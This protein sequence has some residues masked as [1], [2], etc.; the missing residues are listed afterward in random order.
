VPTHGLVLVALEEAFSRLRFSKQLDDRQPRE[1]LMPGSQSERLV[2]NSQLTVDGAVGRA[3]LDDRRTLE[4]GRRL[5]MVELRPTFSGIIGGDGLEVIST[6]AIHQLPRDPG[7]SDVEM[8]LEAATAPVLE[9]SAEMTL[10]SMVESLLR[11]TGEIGELLVA[12]WQ[13]RRGDPPLIRQPREQW[14]DGPSVATTGFAGH[15]PGS[16]PYNPS[17][18]RTD[19]VL[20][21]RLRAASLGDAAR[22]AWA[23]FD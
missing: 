8:F 1:L 6:D 17:Q 20:V 15:A 18:L 12:L 13:T 14:P 2:E 10:T 19:E 22:G 9:E 7:R 3:R 21:R 4:G 11:L 16:T 5:Q 23:G